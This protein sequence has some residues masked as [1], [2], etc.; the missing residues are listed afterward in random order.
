MVHRWEYAY[1][2]EL[3]DCDAKCEWDMQ[4]YLRNRSLAS[5]HLKRLMAQIQTRLGETADSLDPLACPCSLHQP[6]SFQENGPF[7]RKKL[8]FHLDS[9]LKMPLFGSA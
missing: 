3:Y 8:S 1:A 6:T 7:S 4:G 5:R 9:L 2:Q